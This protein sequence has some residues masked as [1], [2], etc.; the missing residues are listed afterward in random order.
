MTAREQWPQGRVDATLASWTALFPQFLNPNPT[1]LREVAMRRALL[2]ALDRQ[3]FTDV[4]QG[5]LSP[6]A[7]SLFVP[8]TADYPAIEPS[9]VKYAYDPRAAQQLLDGLGL[10]KGTDGTYRDSAGQ[11]LSMEIRTTRDDLR[12]RLLPSIAAAWQQLGIA[13]EPVLIP[14]QAAS[15]RSYRS[16]YP[17]FELTRQPPEPQRLYSAEVPTPE[18]NFR[19]NNRVRYASAELDTLLDRYFTTIP[20][21]E[22]LQALGRVAQ[23]MTEQLVIMGIFYTVEPAMVNNRLTGITSRKVENARHPW[24]AH[25]WDVPV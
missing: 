2:H 10:S 4:L 9:I 11:R 17:A 8:G 16:T 5:G 14:T 25:E 3:Q 6:I 13:T 20:K 21:P 7:H 22:R 15:D 24:N 19:G 23:H 1:V 18:N 12:E